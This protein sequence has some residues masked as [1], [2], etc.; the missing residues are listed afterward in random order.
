MKFCYLFLV[1][2][3]FQCYNYC[4]GQVNVV[5]GMY[6]KTTVSNGLYLPATSTFKPIATLTTKIHLV[7]KTY[8]A[9]IHYQITSYGANADFQS[10]LLINYANAGSLVHSG[11]Q[12]FKTATGFYMVNLNPGDY[13][14]E[15]YY[16]SPVDINMATEWDWQTAILQVVWAEDAYAVSDS[17]KCDGCAATNTYNNW[18]PIRDIE[19][20]LHLPNPRVMLSAYQFSA[21]MA[22]LSHVVTALNVD[23]F[24]QPTTTLLKGNNVF[25]DLHGAWAQYYF[26]GPHYFSLMYRTFA[27]L[28]FTDCK[29][30]YT[31]NKNLYAMMLPPSCRVISINPETSTTLDNSNTWAPTDLTH[32]FTLSKQSHV[33]IMY[34]FSG[35]GGDSHIVMRL[36]INS[37]PQKHTVSLTGNTAYAGNFGLW[38]GS[39]SASQHKVSLD[40]RTPAKTTHTVS[41]DPE[42]LNRNK[43]M[44]RAMTIIHC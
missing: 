34:Q 39:L 25:L 23:G 2:F 42:W 41:R 24:H 9:F 36:S 20:V 4:Y 12:T 16:K 13:N 5:P 31:D 11:N 6:S 30:K 43:W 15:V 40:Y 27:G 32:S 19:A 14:I 37:V 44:N 22:S 33:I 18:G 1:C 8:A 3:L 35:D 28:T 38:Q 21:R 26:T 29:E 10:K 7:N 17:I